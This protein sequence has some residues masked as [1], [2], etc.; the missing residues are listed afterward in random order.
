MGIGIQQYFLEIKG[1][2]SCKVST[3]FATLVDFARLFLQDF[4]VLHK[5]WGII[6]DRKSSGSVAEKEVK[7]PI[8][9]GKAVIFRTKPSGDVWQFRMW[10]TEEQEYDRRSLRTRDYQT[11]VSRAEDR[12]FK[13]HSD[14]KSGRKLFGIRLGEL[15][16]KYQEWRKED[17]IG[18]QIT[19]GRLVTI[20]SQ[21]KH[22]KEYKGA[23][24]KMSE[25][26]RSSLF[27]Y[28]QWRRANRGAQ[29]VTIRNEQV[30]INHMMG[31]AF[32][33]GYVHFSEFDFPKIR[34]AEVSRRDTFSLQEYDALV[35]Y[36]RKWVSKNA[37]PDEKLRN[38]RLM[39]RDCILIA[40]N[41]MVRPGELWQLTWGDVQ[42][43]EDVTDEKDRSV[44]LV[45]LLIRP[46][47]SKVRKSRPITCRG[48]EYL[49]V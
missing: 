49:S 27:D 1:F 36:M 21:L 34:I 40:S 29:E 13:I 5:L 12:V 8:L 23:Q 46:E 18:G 19:A 7:H 41:L 25:L 9:G 20:T 26:D 6:V 14:I 16:D 43:Y 22:L 39:I 44:T 45:T 24:T 15:V 28:A 32:R 2:S 4:K 37:E 31:F 38:E 48:G 11:A 30:T 3:N 17:V 33:N 10:I 35:K 47:T 42:S